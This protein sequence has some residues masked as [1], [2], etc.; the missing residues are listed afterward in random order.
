VADGKQ[1]AMPQYKK[2][3]NS[4]LFLISAI[5]LL[6]SACKKGE[7]PPEHYFGRAKVAASMLFGNDST[8]VFVNGKL[9]DTLPKA[10]GARLM[11]SGAPTELR[12]YDL[13]TGK[14][15]ADTNFVLQPNT[16]HSFTVANNPLF[17][18]YG[19]V[20]EGNTAVVPKD[21]VDV[22]LFIDISDDLLP[23]QAVNI[24]ITKWSSD[25]LETETEQ[26][27]INVP[28]R[29]LTQKLRYRLFYTDIPDMT[30]VRAVR[31][32]NPVTNE[33]IETEPF[34]LGFPGSDIYAGKSIILVFK[35]SD[36]GNP[37]YIYDQAYDAP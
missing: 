18:V 5:I 12:F 36:P 26:L 25:F 32:K 24:E 10:F 15:I 6:V 21:S 7:L 3:K 20:Q 31:L 33:Y 37:T 29:Q 19:F 8:I 17:D 30:I 2:M 35:N 23:L 11:E 4:I 13:K 28:K 1:E 34:Y 9:W 14:L 22:Q 27:F 16:V